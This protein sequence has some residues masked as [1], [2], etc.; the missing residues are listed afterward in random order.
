[1]QIIYFVHLDN[2]TA[3]FFTEVVWFWVTYIVYFNWVNV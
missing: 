1:M 2:S 3:V